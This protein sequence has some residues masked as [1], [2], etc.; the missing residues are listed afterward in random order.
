M[1][2]SI[3]SSKIMSGLERNLSILM[4]SMHCHETKILFMSM[5]MTTSD[6]KGTRCFEPE[7]WLGQLGRLPLSLGS[8]Y[9]GH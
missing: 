4:E 1:Q 5:M 6:Y 8:V 9:D 7:L 3:F 2:K